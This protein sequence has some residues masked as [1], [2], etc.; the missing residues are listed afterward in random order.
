LNA[1]LKEWNREMLY[2]WIG[3]LRPEVESI[4]ASVQES[5]TDFLSQPLIN[6]RAGGQLHDA[7]GKCVGMLMIFEHDNR[8]A[9]EALVNESPYRKAGLYEDY[10]LYEFANEIG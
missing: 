4:P 5:A 10:R 6:I 1:H 3:F 7:S 9:A 2:A 8:A